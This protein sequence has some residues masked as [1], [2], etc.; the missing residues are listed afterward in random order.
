VLNVPRAGADG[1]A[2]LECPRVEPQVSCPQT[3][4]DQLPDEIEIEI[5]P[6]RYDVTMPLIDGRVT[7]EGVKL[8]PSRSAPP[9]TMF[10]PDN[11]LPR[12]DFGLVDLNMGSW[13]PA[14]EAGWEIAPLP[15]F[16]KRKHLHTYLFCRN[17]VGIRWPSGSKRS[18]RIATASTWVASPG[19]P[20]A[21]NGR[22][23]TP[24]GRWRSCPD[25]RPWWKSSWTEMRTRAW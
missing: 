7:V 4:E 11:P 22:G 3:Q 19:S 17:D 1:H 16:S 10:G 5:T 13:L 20:L 23:T 9:G 21:S 24:T 6:M 8:I 25:G 18:S 2:G 12:G 15:V 14:I